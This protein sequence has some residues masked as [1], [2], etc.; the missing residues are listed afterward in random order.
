M[1]PTPDIPNPVPG[2]G[3]RSNPGFYDRYRPWRRTFEIGFWV[4][5]I[6]LNVVFNSITTLIDIRRAGLHRVAA[7]EPV[8]WELSSGLLWLA[9]VPVIVGF[10]RRHPLHWD[11]WRRW[12]PPH[13]AAS[14]AVSLVHVC[15]MVALRIAAYRAYDRHYDFGNW[16]T[17]LFYEYLKDVRSYLGM[18]LAIEGYRLLMRRLQGEA[19][20]LDAPEEGPPVESLER[21]KRFLVRKLRREFLVPADDIEWLQATGNYVNLRVGAHDYLLRS[22]IA[23]IETKLDPERFVRI[24][25]SYIVNLGQV[26]SIEPLEAGEARVH[27]RDGAT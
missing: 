16:P 24:H 20:L 2:A 25:R 18:V 21:P 17:E 15:G 12:W 23:G 19:R 5:T 4:L 6:G 22:T 1:T 8:V 14:V 26:A 13:L 11:T 9:L 3:P 7:W 10:S 27:L